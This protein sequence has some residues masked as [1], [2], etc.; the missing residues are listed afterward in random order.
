MVISL[1]LLKKY[2]IFFER[3][4]LVGLGMFNNKFN[5][6]LALKTAK[7]TFNCANRPLVYGINF[8]LPACL[9]AC[10]PCLTSL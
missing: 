8:A 5:A 9:P 3:I 10:L 7:K 2:F 4:I 1:L 6:V